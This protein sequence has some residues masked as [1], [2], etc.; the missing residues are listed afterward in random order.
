MGNAL[1]PHFRRI[2]STDA[3]DERVRHPSMS[4]VATDGRTESSMLSLTA[5]SHCG[6]PILKLLPLATARA[7]D[8]GSAAV[9]VSFAHV[10]FEAPHPLK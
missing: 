4:A 7:D 3:C 6:L 1:K 5:A 10:H 2:A 9:R 8:A